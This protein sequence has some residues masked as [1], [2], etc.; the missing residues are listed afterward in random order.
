MSWIDKILPSGV[1]KDETAEKRVYVPEGLWMKCIKCDA[2]LYWP[3]LER[4]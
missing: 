4:F 3:D 1:R 2:M